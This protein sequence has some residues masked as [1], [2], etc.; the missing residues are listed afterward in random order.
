MTL[1]GPLAI[2]ERPAPSRPDCQWVAA[3]AAYDPHGRIVVARRTR[4]EVI[5]ALGA[6]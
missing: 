5:A 3:W 1:H 2:R 6:R 4:A